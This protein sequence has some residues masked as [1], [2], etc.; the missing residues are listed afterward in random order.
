MENI[1]CPHC[2]SD[3]LISDFDYNS[4]KIYYE[5]QECNNTFSE[6]D[7]VYC[8]E[9]DEQIVEGY[10]IEYDGMIFCSKKCL[11]KYKKILNNLVV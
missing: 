2:G 5:C 9:C 10:G 4:G 8:D 3:M 6:N 11:E 1:I 7:I